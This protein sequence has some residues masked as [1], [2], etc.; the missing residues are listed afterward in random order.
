MADPKAWFEMYDRQGTSYGA[1]EWIDVDFG[2]SH[3]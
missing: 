2:A 1:M 3:F